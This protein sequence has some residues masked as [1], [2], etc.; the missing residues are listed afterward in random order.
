M[1]ASELSQLLGGAC[2]AMAA[3]GPAFAQPQPTL[4]MVNLGYSNYLDGVAGP[5][6]RLQEITV[7]YQAAK[8]RDADG[9][10]VASPSDVNAVGSQTQV[11]F[12]ARRRI[13]GAYWG[14]D[15]QL[16]IARIE[17]RLGPRR[18]M[19]E[20]GLG[21][22]IVSPLILQWPRRDA[23]RTA[24][25]PAA[26]AD[27]HPSDRRLRQLAPGQPWRSCHPFQS[28]LCGDLGADAAVGSDGAASLPL[29]RQE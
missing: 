8:F 25:F 15:V 24:V 19:T 4:P 13:L 3:V 22:L 18:K 10:T 7:F 2:A 5:G 23:L 26:F 21:D 12:L 1:P 11:G 28:I 14:A 9:R 29:E 6:W 16:P 17:T 27:G 20:T